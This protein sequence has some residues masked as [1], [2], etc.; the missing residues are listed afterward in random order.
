MASRFFSNSARAAW[1]SVSPEEGRAGAAA[2]IA[3]EGATTRVR[4]D[5]RKS[6]RQSAVDRRMIP[7]EDAAAIL[8]PEI[9]RQVFPY[10]K[11]W[12]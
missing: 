4:V 11:S 12:P 10:L 1:R 6:A 5:R 3:A 7:P 8:P 9:A 2:R